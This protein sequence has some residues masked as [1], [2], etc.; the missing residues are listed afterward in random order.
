MD[1]RLRE[2]FSTNDGLSLF[3]IGPGLFVDRKTREK[4][5]GGA[6]LAAF[7]SDQGLRA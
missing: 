6:G 1:P 5:L 7:D 3:V 4:C 2:S